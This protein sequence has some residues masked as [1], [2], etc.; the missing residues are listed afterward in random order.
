MLANT[1]EQIW[2][3]FESHELTSDE[4]LSGT[5]SS[6]HRSTGVPDLGLQQELHFEGLQEVSEDLEEYLEYPC[7]NDARCTQNIGL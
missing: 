6:V 7:T 3:R 2:H 5:A 1:P 4:G